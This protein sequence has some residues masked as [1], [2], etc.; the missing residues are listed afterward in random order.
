LAFHKC[1][2]IIYLEIRVDLALENY[3]LVDLAVY[4]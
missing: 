4:E 1:F 3:S 2:M